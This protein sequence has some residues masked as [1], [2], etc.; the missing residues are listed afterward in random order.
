MQL[1]KTALKAWFEKFPEEQSKLLFAVRAAFLDTKPK[2]IGVAV[3]GGGDSMALLNLVTTL[4]ALHDWSVSAV[5][6]DHQMR[7]DSTVEAQFVSAFCVTNGIPHETIKWDGKQAKGNFHKAA[8][9]SRYRLIADWAK[10]HDLDVVALGHTENDVAENFLMRLARKSGADGLAAMEKRFGRNG[11]KWVRPLLQVSREE[12]RDYLKSVDVAWFDDPSNDDPKYSRSQARTILDALEPLGI[13]R[14]TLARVSTQLFF[15][16]SALKHATYKHSKKTELSGGDIVIPLL[17]ADFHFET[18]RRLIV[19]AL[20]FVSGAEH[21]PRSDNMVSIMHEVETKG[22]GTVHGCLLIENK[23]KNMLEKTL[24]ITREY[25]AVKGTTSK[26]TE[27]WDGRWRVDGPH[28]DDL[29]VR[30]LGDGILQCPDW[31]ETGH[32][33]NSL[34]SSPSIWRGNT[35]IAAPLAG[36]NPKWRVWI[37]KDFQTFLLSH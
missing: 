9:D 28:E 30:A 13:N 25:N 10:A 29:E 7:D 18:K 21:G 35:L 27:I 15:E 26:T 1:K 33:R 6:V 16:A 14:K 23:P 36:F 12:L 31:R 37:E 17:D 34:R 3:S 11:I 2:R 5:T 19:E 24:R 8:R 32:P 22:I 20:K 4:S